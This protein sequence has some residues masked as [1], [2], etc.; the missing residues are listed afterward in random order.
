MNSCDNLI[1]KNRNTYLF[2][3]DVEKILS[4]MKKVAGMPFATAFLSS[5]RDDGK[6]YLN[7]KYDNDDID[8]QKYIKNWLLF[9][10][11]IVECYHVE[12]LRDDTNV[13]RYD[14]RHIQLC[15][16]SRYVIRL[17]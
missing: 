7:I 14:K 16:E 11:D 17:K 13:D 15:D 12:Y 9:N 6:I 8:A 4:V 5:D 3:S 2:K 1:E 10:S